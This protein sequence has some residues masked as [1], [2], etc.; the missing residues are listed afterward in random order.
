MVVREDVVTAQGD[1]G[2][3]L[4]EAG[5]AEQGRVILSQIVTETAALG[6]DTG[7]SYIRALLASTEGL[8]GEAW[9]SAGNPVAAEVHYERSCSRRFLPPTRATWRMPSRP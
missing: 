9:E 7:D 8:T 3:S 5:E 2:H 4:V 1:V 6:K